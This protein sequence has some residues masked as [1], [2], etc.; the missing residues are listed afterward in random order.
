MGQS[1]S[2]DPIRCWG[3]LYLHFIFPRLSAMTQL[4][5]GFIYLLH[6]L[7]R[8][9]LPFVAVYTILH[10]IS[11]FRSEIIVSTWTAILAYALCVPVSLYS[12]QTIGDLLVR[13]RA[14]SFGAILAPHYKMDSSPGS[15]LSLLTSLRVFGK[16]YP[17]EEIRV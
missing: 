9:C 16:E 17:G 10:G 12:L 11:H 5:P 13:W 6:H 3:F 14:A 7:P 4:A 2:L 15:I 8:L 1:L